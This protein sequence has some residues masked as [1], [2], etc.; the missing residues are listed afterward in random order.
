MATTQYEEVRRQV[1][2]LSPA[3]QR[4]LLA[5]LSEQIDASPEPTT[6][7]L[8]LQGLGKDIWADLDAQEYVKQERASWN[9]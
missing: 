7:I 8:Q 5:E 2:S 4:R 3:E 9:G 6:S 1:Q